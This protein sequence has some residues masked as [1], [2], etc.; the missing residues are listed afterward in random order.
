M[1]VCVYCF[2]SI[3]FIYFIA[4]ESPKNVGVMVNDEAWSYNARCRWFLHTSL[5]SFNLELNQVDFIVE[6][7]NEE[8]K[9]MCNKVTKSDSDLVF[10]LNFAPCHLKYKTQKHFKILL[11]LMDGWNSVIDQLKLF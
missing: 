4:V 3:L 2:C 7:M 9:Q 5:N 6:W 8:R 10:V 11:N 1:Y